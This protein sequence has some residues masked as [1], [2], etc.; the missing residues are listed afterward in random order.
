MYKSFPASR[1]FATL[2]FAASI[3]LA[4]AADVTGRIKGSVT[5]PSGAVVPNTQVVATNQAT[6]VKYF[7]KTQSDGAY[8]FQSLPVGTYSIG[9]TAIG[10]KSFAASGIVLNID[11]EYVEPIQLSTGSAAETVEVRADAVQVNTT[12]MQLNNVVDA[13]QIVAYPLVSRSFT[14]LELILP[15]VQQPSDRFGGNYSVNGSESQQSS[16][17]ING[18][19]TNDFALN[20]IGIEPNIDA[21]DQFNLI[22]GPLNA[23]YS[24]NSGAIVSTVVKAGT[25]RFHGDA[26]EFYRDTFLNTPGFFNTQT[27]ATGALIKITPPFHQNLFGG[28]IGGPILKDKLF[29]FAAYQGDRSRSPQSSN[30][31]PF[32]YV[33]T[34]AQRGGNFAGEA[35][36]TTNVIPG[37]ITIPGCIS[38]TDTWAACSTKLQGMFP[39]TA[40]NPISAKLLAKFIPAP[41]SGADEFQFN[42]TTTSVQDQGLLRLDFNPTSKNQIDFVGIYQHFPSSD[43]TPFT[44]PTLPGFG[45]VSTSEIRQIT[46][47]YTRQ[48]SATSVNT[49][50]VHYTRFNLGSVEPQ[51]VVSPQSYGFDIF[52]Q[53]TASESLPL[54]TIG[55]SPA[56]QQAFA[57]GFSTNGPQPRIDQNYQ[58]DDNF[59]KTIGNHNLKF[60]YDG[61][62]F[63][64]DNEFEST[65]NG[66][67]SFS[68]VQNADSS[69]DPILD[70][71]LG[72][73]SSYS[74]TAGGRI[75]AQSYENYLY[76]QDTWKAASNLTLDYG[77]G[78]QIDQAVHSKQ[79]GNE[80]VN[81]FVP[82]QQ[83]K[84]FPTAPLS[85]NFPGD[86]G[87]N[88]AQGATTRYTD[89]GPRIGFAYSPDLGILSAGNAH[90]FSIRGG[91]GIY[92]NRTEEEPALQN[93]NQVPF[94]INSGGINDAE[95]GTLVH[96]AFAN[97]YENINTGVTIPNVFPAT[98]P[99]PGSTNIVF[100]QSALYI[101]QYAPGFR[102]PYA[103]NY[104]LTVERELP[105]QIVAIASYVG[106]LGRHNQD[107]VEGNPVTTA[108]HDAC[109][110]DPVCQSVDYYQASVY[111]T[112][113]L[114]PQA[115]DPE[116]GQTHFHSDAQI[117]SEGSSN[118]NAL[119]LSMTKGTTHGLSGQ[120]SYTFAHALD[121][122][123]SY[124]GGGFGG[125]RGYNQYDPALNYGNADFDTRHR[126][127]I[128]PIYTV[129]THGGDQLSLI[130]LLASNW[131][132]SSISTFATGL[133]FD[134]SYQGGVSYSLYCANGDFYYT[135]PDVPNQIAPLQRTNPHNTQ[136]AIRGQYFVGSVNSYQIANSNN[137]GG[138]APANPTFEDEALGTFG[139]VSRNKYHGPGIDNTNLTLAKN[140]PFS[141]E[142]PSHY[143]QLRIEAYNIFNHTNFANPNGNPNNG[144]DGM[145]V[146]TSTNSNLT[147]R[148]YQLVGKIY[149]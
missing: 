88:N 109:L 81:C 5:D 24:R 91:F 19:D 97:P 3:S 12:D 84:I 78:W 132:V 74:Q 28:T 130:N 126:L 2:A 45:D 125:E 7:T 50:S 68:N 33:P 26:F 66:A 95:T 37:T 54:I 51:N 65:N 116:T 133:P 131:Q 139:N 34:V 128:A 72:N 35:L 22:T 30:N 61:R 56:G 118:Y 113:T 77:L 49:L 87:C 20:S 82:G 43:T 38:G 141:K 149:F 99:K 6:G 18:A 79:F 143:I 148:E 11:Q 90:K 76:A 145:G 39:T 101:S 86:P 138:V 1:L 119:E 15:G 110:A 120:V 105:G 127:V 146:I 135:C 108:G 102:P 16:Y 71:L 83:S 48:L 57:I 64:V 140:V 123:S 44:G 136:A 103:E 67:F 42:P 98:F 106:S 85:L 92:Y 104:Q 89:F 134:I 52:P 31:A 129:P 114:Y 13:A 23:E 17:L 10:F 147:N 96:P 41:N 32:S 63:N 117:Q 111:P 73:P 36:S 121:T 124:E 70:F 80:G 100:P 29:F 112:H 47:D 142:N 94:G 55:A 60:G 137:P 122:V 9:T 27:S 93:L 46:V 25:S 144:L 59:S 14:S 115:I 107:T 69:G 8:I 40:F 62:R 4:H 21:L 75:S 53:N 58:V